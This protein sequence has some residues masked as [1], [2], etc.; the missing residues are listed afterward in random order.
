MSAL[1]V[2]F[3]LS[4]I[5]GFALGISVSYFALAVSGVAFALL[6]ATVLHV[7]GF[8]AFSG[9]AMIVACLIVNQLA[10]LAGVFF[11]HRRPPVLSKK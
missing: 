8:S 5:I 6:S 3:M 7:Q 2:V 10:Y 9:I 11:A 1:V 4:A